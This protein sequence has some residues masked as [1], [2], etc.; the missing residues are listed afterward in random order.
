MAKQQSKR[1]G[2]KAKK[3]TRAEMRVERRAAA[4]ALRK[5]IQD[6]FGGSAKPLKTRDITDQDVEDIIA[7]VADGMTVTSTCRRLGISNGQFTSRLASGDPERAKRYVRARS[8]QAEAWADE[9]ADIADEA[10]NYDGEPGAANAEVSHRN[11]RVNTRKWLMGKYNVKFAEK[12][13]HV[14]EGNPDKPLRSVTE[15]MTEKEAAEAYAER[16]RQIKDGLIP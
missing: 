1:I 12:T 9:I 5:Q 3:P 11:L 6:A 8:L 4:A 2:G 15:H 16:L 10:I 7:A 13:T 14:L